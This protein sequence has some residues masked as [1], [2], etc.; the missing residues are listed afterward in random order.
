ME[1]ETAHWIVA[2]VERPQAEASRAGRGGDQRVG[3]LHPVRSRVTR[4][5][6]A[7]AASHY[8][9]EHDLASSVEERLGHR[10]LA[11]ADSGPYLRE[12]H[13]TAVRRHASMLDGAN[14]IADLPPATKRLD[15]DV[16]VEEDAGYGR[17]RRRSR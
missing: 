11:R 4:Q 16:G 2:P 5:I 10:F 14:A 7:G 1:D 13:G 8:R 3:D 12:R 17:R 6:R 9:V 15:D